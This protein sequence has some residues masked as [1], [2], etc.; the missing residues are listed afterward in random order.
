MPRISQ[1]VLVSEPDV[2]GR[3]GQTGDKKQSR[4]A[5]ERKIDEVGIAEFAP[6]VSLQ[7]ASDAHCGPVPDGKDE[8]VASSALV[9]PNVL[10]EDEIFSRREGPPERAAEGLVIRKS[11]IGRVRARSR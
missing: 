1:T 2:T 8:V 10:A 6:L 4:M 3:L 9:I 11:L 7:D 5:V